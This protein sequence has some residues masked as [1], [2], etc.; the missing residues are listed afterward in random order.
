M[1]V[2]KVGSGRASPDCAT[3]R[4][5]SISYPNGSRNRCR[6]ACA[7]RRRDQEAEQAHQQDQQL[8]VSLISEHSARHSVQLLMRYSRL[9]LS[10]CLAVLALAAQPDQRRTA[11]RSA[12]PKAKPAAVAEDWPVWGG[13]NRDFVVNTSGLANSW[14]ATGPKKVW[15]RALGDGYSAIAEE[16]G[17]LYTAYGRGS[18]DVIVALDAATGKTVWEYEYENPFT[19]AFS[20]KVG[21]GPYAM[22]Q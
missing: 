9:A 12:L 17:V 5:R 1:T 19:N 3:Y 13:K 2:T 18:K 4:T 22:P 16:S 7:G 8:S 21:P 6:P 20:E 10:L 14:P 11:A 15:S